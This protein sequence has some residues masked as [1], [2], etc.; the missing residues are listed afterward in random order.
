[1]RKGILITG[2]D[3]NVGKTHIAIGLIRTAIAE[4]VKIGVMKPVET[5]CKQR[6]NKL[7]PSD[8]FML[9]KTANMND[10]DQVNLYRF[11]YPVAPY[12][13]QT[14]ENKRINIARIKNAYNKLF[15]ENELVIVEGAGGLLVPITKDFSY[16]DLAK[17]L[18]LHI[19]LIA[20]NK[21]GVINHVLLTIDYIKAHKLD[22]S[23]LIINN[24][25]KKRNVA[26]KTN[27][28]AIKSLLNKGIIVEETGFN[29]TETDTHVY[30]SI[31]KTILHNIG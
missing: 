12:V 26:Q 10:I 20:P 27:V 29:R 21:L 18:S 14:L 9:M 7:I 11:K 15:M 17:D 2:T 24:V 16:A 30:K 28:Q 6:N 8:A 22:L 25:E 4:G 3:T 5:G 31:L 23:G 13:A 1:M 19:L